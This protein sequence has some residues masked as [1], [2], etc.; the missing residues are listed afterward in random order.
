MRAAGRTLLTLFLYLVLVHNSFQLPVD[1]PLDQGQ[2]SE[3]AKPGSSST[4]SLY[5]LVKSRPNLPKSEKGLKYQEEFSN[6]P[7]IQRINFHD[8][9]QANT[10]KE[11]QKLRK[12]D[13]KPSWKNKLTRSIK[14]HI[15]TIQ[16]DEGLLL[17]FES[18]NFKER[19][20]IAAA[21]MNDKYRS[22][23]PV[24][25][26]ARQAKYSRD[27]RRKREELRRQSSIYDLPLINYMGNI[28][29][30]PERP[31]A[32]QVLERAM[33]YKFLY[34]SP[35]TFTLALRRYL[36]D[37]NYPLD[38]INV[39]TGLHQRCQ[40]IAGKK[41]EDEK[42]RWLILQDPTLAVPKMRK[43]K[44]KSEKK[45]VKEAKPLLAS[46]S[47]SRRRGKALMVDEREEE[48][49][50]EISS[51]SGSHQGLFL[52]EMYEDTQTDY[53]SPDHIRYHTDPSTS[54]AS[55]SSLNPIF[56]FHL[57]RPVYDVQ[58]S[59]TDWWH[60]RHF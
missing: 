27:G 21:K 22:R 25:H 18:I 29:S 26:R 16:P 13:A 39:A 52:D 30:F 45:Q 14:A 8:K 41:R 53:L 56:L 44:S 34:L 48:A 11:L 32:L 55:R 31:T 10:I 28:D 58:V 3:S 7:D 2:R 50:E 17:A 57:K 46:S 47:Q 42:K 36:L 4:K 38:K 19:R 60:S 35:V 43:K 15:A 24:K 54:T 1:S 20:K 23:D 49:A 37:S 51:H 12:D 9:D 33:K 6:H 5:D 59:N 40:S